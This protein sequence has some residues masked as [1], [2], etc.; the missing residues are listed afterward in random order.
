MPANITKPILPILDE[1]EPEAD[2]QYNLI[3]MKW[4]F[5]QS[6]IPPE[7]TVYDLEE[8]ILVEPNVISLEK[9]AV[10]YKCLFAGKFYQKMCS[11]I[12]TYKETY[13]VPQFEKL[14]KKY[15][16]KVEQIMYLLDD[17]HYE[18]VAVAS[19]DETGIP[20]NLL[21]ELQEVQLKEKDGHLQKCQ[22]QFRCHQDCV[23]KAFAGLEDIQATIKKSM[24]SY[25]SKFEKKFRSYFRNAFA[26]SVEKYRKVIDSIQLEEKSKAELWEYT[27]S[28]YYKLITPKGIE[29]LGKVLTNTFVR[30]PSMESARNKLLT[31]YNQLMAMMGEAEQSRKY[32]ER[33]STTT[34]AL[35]GDYISSTDGMK[36]V[37]E[38]Y[39]RYFA[40]CRA[41]MENAL[42]CLDSCIEYVSTITEN[43]KEVEEMMGT[44]PAYKNR[45]ELLVYTKKSLNVYKNLT[46][47]YTTSA[48]TCEENKEEIEKA[49]KSVERYK[50]Y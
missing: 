34:Y 16:K 40:P 9:P 33:I 1:I 20:E 25:S 41:E 19:S 32:A 36:G 27:K 3:L 4:R 24:D 45:R 7:G 6:L 29:L 21:K 15:M 47:F 50:D 28:N 39:A 42:E 10:D 37:K 14:N 46:E 22:E 48:S 26:K 8:R 17:N 31:S 44:I 13:A 18:G 30:D 43:I 5:H 38:R 11:Y 12:E 35:V 2:R 23:Q 49:Y